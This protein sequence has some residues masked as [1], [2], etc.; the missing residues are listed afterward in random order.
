MKFI[1]VKL[2]YLRTLQIQAKL[3]SE[4]QMSVW[5]L[6][7]YNLCFF[8]LFKDTFMCFLFFRIIRRTAPQ[9]LIRGLKSHWKKYLNV[10]LRYWERID[11]FR[12]FLLYISVTRRYNGSDV[13][14]KYSKFDYCQLKS[15]PFFVTK[16]KINQMLIKLRSFNMFHKYKFG[17]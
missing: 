1:W 6:L 8:F 14:I 15:I 12:T 13:R 17:H 5:D 3:I 2:I 4:T 16:I 7:Y 11:F 9:N 10:A